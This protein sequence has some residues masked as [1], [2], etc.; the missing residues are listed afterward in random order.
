MKKFITISCLTLAAW[1]LMSITL[2]DS[3]EMAKHNNKELL[4]AAEDIVKA[5]NTYKDVRGN[6]L[7]QIS[8]QGAYQLMR[9]SLP[10]SS[11]PSAPDFSSGLDTLA[12]DNEDYLASALTGVVS[13]MIP[14]KTQEEGSLAMQVKFDQILFSGG[15]LINGIR[16]VDRYRSIQQRR[17][18]LVEQELIVKTSEM[19]Y[20]CLL[21]HKLYEVQQ[22]ALDI[23]SQHLAH[24][25]LFNQ[26]GQVSEF[27]LLRAQLEVAKLQPQVLQAKNNYELAAAAFRKQI[28]STDSS[29]APEGEFILPQDFNIDLDTA[30]AQGL[31]DRIELHLAAI[32]TE[33]QQIRYNAEKGNYLP[34]V[35][36]QAGYSLFT[37]ADEYSI[38]SNDFGSQYQVGIGFSIP[39]FTGFSNTSKRIYAKHDYQQSRLQ[40]GEYQDMITLQIRQTHQQL[41]YALENYKVQAQNIS[42]A[43]RS[44]QLAQVRYDNQVGIQLEVFDAQIMLNS[45]KLQYLQ[46]IYE[47]IS[48]DLN[49][50]KAIGYKL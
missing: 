26:E 18:N 10:E 46:S 21:A 6:L 25:R 45:V 35:A 47:V 5:D 48:A 29:L 32:N 42:L 9:T 31:R 34:N 12:T 50:K 23:A 7:P 2:T 15:K 17:Y 16:A 37:A 13:S 19:F 33:I 40:E 30:I 22:E 20:Q 49:L 41:A 38:Q 4:M 43:E 36:L 11:L 39:L 28:G 1:S 27:D 3:I 14:S 8:L 44:L 24:V